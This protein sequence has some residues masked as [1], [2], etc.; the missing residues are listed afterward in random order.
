MTTNWVMQVLIS[1]WSCF[2]KTTFNVLFCLLSLPPPTFYTPPQKKKEKKR[3]TQK[4]HWHY[5]MWCIWIVRGSAACWFERKIFVYRSVYYV[6]STQHNTHWFL[7][8]PMGVFDLKSEN[9]FGKWGH[10]DSAL[11][12]MDLQWDVGIWDFFLSFRFKP[13]L[14]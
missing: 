9:I 13:E 6:V 2:P 4:K 12:Q 8:W 10:C 11:F 5:W 1:A 7:L 14:E 3:H